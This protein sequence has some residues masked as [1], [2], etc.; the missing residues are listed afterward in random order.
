MGGEVKRPLMAY[1]TFGAAYV[2]RS[3]RLDSW[4]DGEVTPCCWTGMNCSSD[5]DPVVVSLDLNSLNLSGPLSPS[6]GSLVHLTYLNLS[7]NG[8]SK[9]CYLEKMYE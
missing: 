7:F 6:I 4:R 3:G 9:L 1:V 8:F 2:L 5:Y